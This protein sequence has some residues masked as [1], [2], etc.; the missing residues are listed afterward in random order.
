M[1]RVFERACAEV[2]VSLHLSMHTRRRL[3]D[4]SLTGYH[5]LI[6]DHGLPAELRSAEISRYCWA[7][8]PLVA[9]TEDTRTVSET[10]FAA[11]Q[12]VYFACGSTVLTCRLV[13]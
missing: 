8:E 1:Q 7:I 9:A 2:C 11:Y 5:Y 10:P 6:G 13:G 12:C 4:E 3:Q